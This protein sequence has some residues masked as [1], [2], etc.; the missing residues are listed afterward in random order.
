MIS[1]NELKHRLPQEFMNQINEN[2]SPHKVDDILIGILSKRYTTL[3]VNTIKYDMQSL[4]RYFKEI[5]IKFD[6]VLW[7][8]DALVIK[9]ATE[10]DIQ[11]LDIYE[12][13]YIYLQSLS[14]MIPPLVLN[15]SENEKVLD[16]TAA[17]GS[18]TTQLSA[19]MKN[20]GYILANE[21]DKIRYERLKFNVD[22]Q[23][24][25]IVE[26]INGRGEKIGENYS[27]LFDK[28][29]LDTP[30]S[31]EG[32]FTINN[33]Q[34]YRDWSIKKVKELSKLQKKLFK[35]AYDSLK[36]GGIMVYST[37]TIN[38]EENEYILDWA[39]ENLNLKIMNIDIEIKD[40]LKGFNDDVNN[41]DINK[42]IRIL[43]SKDM[44]GFFVVKLIKQS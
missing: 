5:N 35:S 6:R 44:E 14:S 2:Y 38:K 40:V 43:P 31:G 33:V 13:G 15:P 11:K 32:R 8:K 9:N 42:A 7:Y 23:G 1:I 12:K 24:A 29:L 21:L 10:K 28:V 3:R 39:L 16:L 19:L 37:C 41:K 20:K 30:C 27:E 26:V 4:I 18:K 22:S 17:P 25:S 34:S 36:P